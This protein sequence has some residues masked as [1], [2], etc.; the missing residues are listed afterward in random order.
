[1]MGKVSPWKWLN[2]QTAI[3]C[4]PAAPRADS[5]LPS[6]FASCLKAIRPPFLAWQCCHCSL[7][8][9]KVTLCKSK[10]QDHK[11]KLRKDKPGMARELIPFQWMEH[12]LSSS[13]QLWVDLQ[14]LNLEH[15]LIVRPFSKLFS[16][17][18]LLRPS[19]KTAKSWLGKSVLWL[20]KLFKHVHAIQ[21][22]LFR[23]VEWSKGKTI[24]LYHNFHRVEFMLNT[25]R[26]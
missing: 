14:F 4:L 5:C 2:V 16:S 12:Q 22:A 25:F 18:E 23:Y 1:M 3:I 24:T 7:A 9:F 15:H 26:D 19:G 21:T 11:M 17:N 6:A 10:I 13:Q 20:L 8:S